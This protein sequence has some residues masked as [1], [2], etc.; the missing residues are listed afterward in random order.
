MVRAVGDFCEECEGGW[1]LRCMGVGLRRCLVDKWHF[2]DRM[3]KNVVL[4][5]RGR[6]T[7]MVQQSTASVVRCKAARF[8]LVTN[9]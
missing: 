5:V 9:I 1:S 3:E 6:E 8:L 7:D 2:K 4:E